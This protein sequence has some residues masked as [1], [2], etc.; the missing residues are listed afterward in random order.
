MAQA[1]V[2]TTAAH[3]TNAM[4][5]K[6]VIATDTIVMEL[7]TKSKTPMDMTAAVIINGADIAQNMTITD[8]ITK[9]KTTSFFIFANCIY[10]P[11]T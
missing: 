6:V 10:I 4:T 8:T 3:I 7:T 2:M 9:D 11:H 1:V 5:A